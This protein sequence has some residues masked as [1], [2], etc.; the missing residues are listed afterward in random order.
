MEVIF[1]LDTSKSMDGERIAQL[2]H[3][4]LEILTG[5]EEAWEKT[6]EVVNVRV[7]NFD[8]VAKFFIGKATESV[9]IDIACE[10]WKNLIS[11]GATDTAHAVRLC[12]KSIENDYLNNNYD[13]TIVFLIT[14]GESSDRDDLNDAIKE[15]KQILQK[16]D[17]K[18][19]FFVSIGVY[20]YC[21][22]EIELFANL[23]KSCKQ[24]FANDNKS[25]YTADNIYDL[26]QIVRGVLNS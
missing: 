11:K 5:L 4:M 1:L 12:K 23:N 18:S 19:M 15:M 21:K 24:L 20:D 7:I 2:N 16:I 10:S 14:D 13:K 9:R 25:V 8:N 6:S 17:K 26:S 3:V 22:Q